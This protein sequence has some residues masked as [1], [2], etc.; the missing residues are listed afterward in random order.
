MQVW[1]KIQISCAVDFDNLGVFYKVF[2]FSKRANQ[3]IQ[4]KTVEDCQSF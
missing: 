4:R 3:P 2:S 1:P